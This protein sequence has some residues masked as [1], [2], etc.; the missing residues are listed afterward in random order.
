MTDAFLA[1]PVCLPG[2]AVWKGYKGRLYIIKV[3]TCGAWFARVTL[4][5]YYTLG[6]DMFNN[7]R[8]G[9]WRP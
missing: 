4:L 3:G 9:V 1:L 7:S 6:V 2:T 8:G 5:R